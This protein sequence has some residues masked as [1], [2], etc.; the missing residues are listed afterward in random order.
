M[1]I[2][3]DYLTR[4]QVKLWMNLQG[5][6]YDDIVDYVITSISRDIEDYCHRQFNKDLAPSQRLYDPTNHRQAVVDDFYTTTG[7]VLETD[8]DGDGVFETTWTPDDYEL[9]PLNGIRNGR[10]GEPFWQIRVRRNSTKR[11]HHSDSAN[12]RVTAAWGWDA[13]PDNVLQA[14]RQLAADTFQLKDNRLGVA[15][16]DQFGT[17]IRVRDNQLARMRLK[18]YIR[19]SVFCA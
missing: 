12:I 2:G 7:F 11:F 8:D 9:R 15:G 13:I 19:G 5:T 6:E 17:V 1:A 4:D 16:T 14:A 18:N 3:D 10:P